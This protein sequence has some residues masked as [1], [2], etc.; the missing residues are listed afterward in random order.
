MANESFVNPSRIPAPLAYAIAKSAVGYVS[1]GEF[2]VTEL[3]NP[4]QIAQLK[5]RFPDGR[6][7]PTEQPIHKSLDD[8]VY[9]WSGSAVDQQ[10]DLFRLPNTITHTR[11]LVTFSHALLEKPCLISMEFDA[12]YP[13]AYDVG[14]DPGLP[15]WPSTMMDLKESSVKRFSRGVPE[16]YQH[17]LRFYAALV[18]YGVENK[19]IMAYNPDDE[20]FPFVHCEDM[21]S[22]YTIDNLIC[23]V[24]YRD[25]SKTEAYRSASIP[26][27]EYPSGPIEAHS[28][29]PGEHQ[30]VLNEIAQRIVFHRQAAACEDPDQLPECS[31]QDRWVDESAYFVVYADGKGE[32]RAIKNGKYEHRIHA[33]GRIEEEMKKGKKARA[34]RIEFREGFN[35]RCELYCDAKN[36][37]AQFAAIKNRR[38]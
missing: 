13:A 22:K 28:V 38:D 14:V 10:L 24:R 23:A 21:L 17:Q 9:T 20:D 16:D 31:P 4:P 1:V 37:C 36:V 35:M 6:R 27:K 12:L 8:F 32:G 2:S 34:L 29:D 7:T 11:M 30:L 15:P 26:G 25:W 5:R 19:K 18:R 3:I 33:E